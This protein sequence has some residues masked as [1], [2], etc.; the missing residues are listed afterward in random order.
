MEPTRP[1]ARA[2]PYLESSYL[3]PVAVAV[4]QTVATLVAGRPGGHIHTDVDVA[5]WV[6]LFVGPAALFARRRH[7]VLVLAI[8]LLATIGPHGSRFVYLS[9]IVAF[10]TVV[11][12]GR[13]RAAWV[14]AVGG[15]VL[16]LWINPLLWG[17]AP[18]NAVQAGLLAAWL[19]VLYATGEAVR[20]RQERATTA[21]VNRQLESRRRASELRLQMARDLHD[22]I[23]HNI[24][25]INV[26]AGVGLDLMDQHPEQARAALAAIRSVSKE[27]LEEL[28]S[29]LVG[30]RAED[31][32][33]ERSDPRAPAGLARLDELIQL[34]NGVGLRVR[35][36]KTGTPYPLA[37]AVDLAAYRIVQESLT[38]IARHASGA[39]ATIHLSYDDSRLVVE[40]T[41]EA[42]ARVPTMEPPATGTGMGIAGMQER[43]RAVG[44]TLTAGR[45][46]R[47]GFAVRAELP[48]DPKMLAHNRRP[49]TEPDRAGA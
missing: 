32:I 40:V 47:A 23:G 42:P 41:N 31:E 44:G 11:V 12:G 33:G 25:L 18:G 36:E 5:G 3:V 35:L 29:M 8:T 22:V 39:S 20:F 28:R 9:V 17:E 7:P 49:E 30:L 10:V 14:G 15:Y 6:L 46:A 34:S 45:T 24:S 27:A 13:R 21:A 43:A 4:L 19:A 37:T 48:T 16:A 26:Q 1:A 2:R 38:N